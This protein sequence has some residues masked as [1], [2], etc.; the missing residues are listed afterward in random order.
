MIYEALKLKVINSLVFWNIFSLQIKLYQTLYNFNKKKCWI[1]FDTYF[2]RFLSDI[3]GDP[4]KNLIKV[5]FYNIHFLLSCAT[6]FPCRRLSS[7]LGWFPL[8]KSVM[9]ILN[10]LLVLPTFDNGLQHYFLVGSM[11][12]W[13]AC[14]SLHLPSLHSWR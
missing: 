6:F 7:W 5:K 10:Y 12:A 2:V 3:M 14:S 4:V 9:T 8:H 13:L 11:S 1:I